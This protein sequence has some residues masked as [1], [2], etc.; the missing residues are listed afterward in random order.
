MTMTTS[1]DVIFSCRQRR[2]EVSNE[3]RAKHPL[4]MMHQID[5]HQHNGSANEQREDPLSSAS[6]HYEAKTT[7]DS[8]S[9]QKKP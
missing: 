3:G 6:S 8:F 2:A 5:S 7:I 1:V 9:S 4:A